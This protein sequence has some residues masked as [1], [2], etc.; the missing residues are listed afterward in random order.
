MSDLLGKRM[1]EFDIKP[2]PGQA[3][4]ERVVVFQVPDEELAG[5]KVSKDSMIYKPVT[6]QQSDEYRS[7][8]GVIVSAGIQSLKVMCDHGMQIGDIVW[9]APHL[10]YRFVV[11]KTSAGLDIT[12]FFLNV[13]DIVLDEDVLQ[14]VADGKLNCYLDPDYGDRAN[15]TTNGDDI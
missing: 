9:L 7:P 12:V 3:M 1:Q 6:T 2:W 8:R 14:R 5:E 11:G 13:G 15:P 10:P 4:F